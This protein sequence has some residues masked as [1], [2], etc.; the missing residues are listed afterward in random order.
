MEGCKALIFA[1]LRH[2]LPYFWAFETT[3]IS[4]NLADMLFL[5]LNLELLI[6]K[7]IAA[8]IHPNGTRAAKVRTGRDYFRFLTVLS[9][10]RQSYCQ[11][12]EN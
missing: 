11:E 7:I 4:L 2:N 6:R 9:R 8:L 1:G 5:P 10:Q 3:G 12:E